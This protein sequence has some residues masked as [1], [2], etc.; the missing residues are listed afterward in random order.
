MADGPL[1]WCEFSESASKLG[2][3]H[4]CVA[5]DESYT[6]K[7]RLAPP[8]SKHNVPGSKFLW[9]SLTFF[10]LGL[11][12]VVFGVYSAI[13]VSESLK[14]VQFTSFNKWHT[15]TEEDSSDTLM[16]WMPSG[17]WVLLAILVTPRTVGI[18][19]ACTKHVA[20]ALTQ[21]YA[22]A[23]GNHNSLMLKYVKEAN[24]KL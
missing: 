9:C 4:V 18:I 3:C 11:L 22:A 21:H 24:L 13:C 20:L 15:S 14:Y 10:Q 6:I 19:A 16:C 2:S 23:R 7:L 12:S 8:P 5:V 1:D 17:R